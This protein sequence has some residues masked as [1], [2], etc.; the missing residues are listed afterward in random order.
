MAAT[1]RSAWSRPSCRASA[2]RRAYCGPEASACRNCAPSFPRSRRGLTHRAAR[3]WHDGATLFADDA[4]ERRSEPA[5]GAGHERVHRQ[6]RKVA[7]L[8][9]R[10]PITA[11]PYMTWINAGTR[12]DLYGRQLYTNLR[13]LD[14]A[15]ARIILVEEVPAGEKWDAVRDRLRRGHRR[16]H[17]YLRPDI[18]AWV[19][20]FGKRADRPEVE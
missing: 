9:Q 17:R 8:A 14:K 16:E 2:T 20:D 5:S 1:V 11:T 18:A 10:P 7:V 19:A 3:A 6:P 15:G 4:G 13:T 12:P